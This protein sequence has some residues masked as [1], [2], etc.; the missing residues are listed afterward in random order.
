MKIV[1][2]HMESMTVTAREPT[3]GEVLTANEL[4]WDFWRAVIIEPPIED[5]LASEFAEFRSRFLAEIF[6]KPIGK[7]VA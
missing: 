5:F 7:D 4:G 1:T 3:I 6:P 2:I